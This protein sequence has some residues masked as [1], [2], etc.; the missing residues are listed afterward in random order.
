MPPQ[1]RQVLDFPITAETLER[2]NVLTEFPDG[3][4]FDPNGEWSHTFLVWTNHGYNAGN[5]DAGY[6]TIDRRPAG[7]GKIALEVVTEIA[8]LDGIGGRTAASI[9]CRSDS[10]TA[11]ESWT[12]DSTFTGPSGEDLPDQSTHQ[13]ASVSDNDITVEIDGRKSVMPASAPTTGDWCLFDAVQRLPEDDN[14]IT[15]NVLERMLTLKRDQTIRFAPHDTET[16]LG[17]ELRRFTRMGTA[18]LPTDYWLDESNRLVLVVAYNMIYLLSDTAID[19]FN[20]N[21]AKHRA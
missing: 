18:T 16:V 21:L 15:C 13:R 20:G 4:G 7:D 1:E 3:S 10:L 17:H 6:L 11:P 14:P 19:T 8:L 9:R 5:I 12:L 2:I